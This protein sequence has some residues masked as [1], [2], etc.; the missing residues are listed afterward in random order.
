MNQE[1]EA[2]KKEKRENDR[3]TLNNQRQE[4]N[5]PKK[6]VSSSKKKKDD[7]FVDNLTGFLKGEKVIKGLSIQDKKKGDSDTSLNKIGKL[8]PNEKA[9]EIDR[10]IA[11][12][13]NSMAL[14]IPKELAKR[15][16]DKH[17]LDSFYNERKIGEGGGKDLISSG[18]GY[19]V[20]GIGM[21][22]G[23][24]AL[25]VGA[26]SVPKLAEGATKMDKVM[27]AVKSGGQIAKEGAIV[28]GAMGL[29]EVGIREGLNPDEQ[30]WKQNLG[31]VA[32]GTVTG[33]V[34]DPL[35]HGVGKGLSKGFDEGLKK[36][37][38]DLPP[39]TPNESYNI[40]NPRVNESSLPKKLDP[41]NVDQA[42][43]TKRYHNPN[44]PLNEFLGRNT[45]ES[46]LFQM[47]KK[48]NYTKRDLPDF[49]TSQPS[50]GKPDGDIIST[51]FGVDV[52]KDLIDTA[53]PQYWQK[54]YEDFVDH[55]K[56]SYDTNQLTKEGLE[57]LWTQFARYD[58]PVT[59]EQVVD[60]AYTGYKEPT[61]I[62]ANEVWNQLGNRPNVSKNAKKIMGIDDSM[63]LRNKGQSL[64]PVQE[65]P[66][67]TTIKK[68]IYKPTPKMEA[69]PVQPNESAFFNTVA[70]QEKTSPEMLQR[71]QEFDKSY[72]PMSN[73]EV[74][75]FANKFIENDIEKAYQ[76]VK[77]ARKFDPRHV[78]V[79]HRLIDE[80][81]AKGEY[82][83]ALDV[84][85][86]LAEQ[87]T[88]AGQSIQAYSIYGRL[89]VQGQLLRAQRVVNRV[90]EQI[91]KPGKQVKLT[92][93][94]I[95][96]ITHSADSIQRLTGQQE[97][98]NDVINI[99]EKMK[100]GK[101]ATDDELDM[102]R[103]FVTDAKKFVGDTTPKPV[104]VKVKANDV[105]TRD[106]VVDFMSKREEVAK[107]R[108]KKAL[109]RANSLPVDV[110]YDLSI[111]G[112]SKI[113]KGTV[114]F[115]DFTEQMV[116]EFGE[117]VRPYMRQIWDKAAETFNLQSEAMSSKRLSEVEKIVNKATKDKTLSPED[118][119][120]VQKYLTDY[121]RLTGDAKLEASMNLQTTLQLLERPS[122]AQRIST[123]QTIAQLLNPK[124]IVR[125][126]VGNE[127]FY[128]VEQMNKLV[129]TPIDI[130]KS[131]L[132]GSKRTITFRT[133]NQGQY[134][135]NWMTG[136]K[137][138]WK[139]VN[140]MGLQTMYDLGPQ[141]FRSKWNPMTYLEKTLGATLRSFDN[142]GYMRAYNKTIG[143]MA[144]LR[145][146]NEGL[147][148][149]ALKEA[150]AKYIREADE[151]MMH[152]ADSYSKYATFQDS[153]VLANL[154][155]K[156]K[157]GLNKYTTSSEEF[158][159]GDLILKYPKT[160]GNLVTRALEYSPVGLLRSASLL[161]QA[162][163]TK[164]P[165]DERDTVL[166]FSRAIVGTGGFSMMGYVLA[167]LG[168]LTS[169]GDSDYEVAALERNAGKQPSS[170]NVTALQR[171]IGSG[172]DMKEG[173]TKEG[174]TFV[175]FDWA[176]P[177][178][179]AI[180]LGT[181]VNQTLKDNEDKTFSGVVRSAADSGAK[182]IVNMSVLSG[183]NN[184][185]SGNADETWSEKI[186][187]VLRGAAGSFVPTLSNQI[188]QMNNNTARSTYSPDFFEEAKNKVYNRVP[189]LDSVLP[190]AYDTLG[191][192][193]Q[194]FQDNSNNAFNVFLNPSFVS[195]YKPSEEAKF[196][197]DYINQSGDKTVA[198]RFAEKKLDGVPLTGAQRSELQ[199]L[200]GEEVMKG[201]ERV[202]PKLQG[203]TNFEKIKNALNDVLTKA[204]KTAR[205]ELSK[206]VGE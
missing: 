156:A 7:G 111:I 57:D 83:R 115:T 142:A 5:T 162:Y 187:G 152:I 160:P 161:R 170:V 138:G 53:P 134:W 174:D 24:K 188:K 201:F 11:N 87:G 10:S 50:I 141:A 100:K 202:I 77:N 98:T 3:I 6:S 169:S 80:L 27:R 118:A 41:L 93:N 48:V 132:T 200:M 110:F 190:P 120:A 90:N 97:L 30:N 144:T 199:R 140:P 51:H 82:D 130:A 81:Q 127:L 2:K 44:Q 38:P 194:N 71:L 151:N 34:A 108:L 45:K 131:K 105:R 133:H 154:L 19:L 103:S 4:K 26:K 107:E 92:E 37:I 178:S 28:G 113:A 40:P 116:K 121:L 43:N 88:K 149:K 143:E 104:R 56:Q 128:R 68:T 52:P 58:E 79:G 31:H 184:F 173:E 18:L 150:V 155:T 191:N 101:S 206:E 139:G 1:D 126:A 55:V 179:M 177:V 182:T 32:F 164:N 203:E 117:E 94:T 39:S 9:T 122:F 159:L 23:A 158:G 67:Q 69:Q 192:K 109:N 157:K 49:S 137:A 54:R 183:L 73:E 86:R 135:R 25:G 60:M 95:K 63:F 70:K 172:L 129:A 22:K 193:R 42:F 12:F 13:A 61:N 181:G 85:E 145:A 124:T 84:V 35:L 189:T 59:L 17:T 62:N 165:F 185:I 20:P 96:N 76:F 167:D 33:A 74:V 147:K 166:A 36:W 186:E 106:K 195:K 171:F 64:A 205:K 114:K 180:A 72:T 47:A 65:P 136:L 204:G 119:Q 163:R 168:I 123:T 198:P 8:K 46:D 14:G 197:L 112:A 16:G 153:T 102:V 176:Q 99:M 148:G 75:N 125:N 21:V 78:T 146:M 196:V 66:L 29:A 91:I 15:T 175:S 89:S